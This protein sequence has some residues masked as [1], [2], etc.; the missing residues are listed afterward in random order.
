MWCGILCRQSSRKVQDVQEACLPSDINPWLVLAL[1]PSIHT[2]IQKYKT[3][4]FLMPVSDASGG[5]QILSTGC[6]PP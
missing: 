4:N 6:H 5:H 3:L 2:L 1:V